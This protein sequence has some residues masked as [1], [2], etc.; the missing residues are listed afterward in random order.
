M[1]NLR[2]G[3]ATAACV[4]LLGAIAGCDGREELN[5]K[6]RDLPKPQSFALA[7]AT[8]VA[9]WARSTPRDP[10]DRW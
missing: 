2:S 5:P 6:K 4:A 10:S 7:S 3:V 9:A 8:S 1:K